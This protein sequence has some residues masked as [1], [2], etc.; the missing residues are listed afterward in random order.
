MI[1]LKS[2]SQMALERR[3]V[4]P[5]VSGGEILLADLVNVVLVSARYCEVS[6]LDFAS[7]ANNG[8]LENVW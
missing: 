4:L 1:V 5:S 7:E 8:L 3:H 2:S 6:V